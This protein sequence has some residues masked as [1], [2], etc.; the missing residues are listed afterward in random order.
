MTFIDS[1]TPEQRTIHDALCDSQ[2]LAG[3]KAGWNAGSIKDDAK[4]Q[5]EYD[6]LVAS[7]NGHLAGY[8]AAKDAMP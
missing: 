7:R 4:A 3:L 1:L 6:A 5:A 8:R 2:W